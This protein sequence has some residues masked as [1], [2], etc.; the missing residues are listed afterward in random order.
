[1]VQQ[2]L[3]LPHRSVNG[4]NEV[5]D[6]REPLVIIGAN[7]SGKSRLGAWIEQNQEKPEKVHRISAQRALDFSEYAPLKSLE[8]AENELFFGI[9][10]YQL[11][12]YG[13]AV[14]AKNN[15][16]WQL[17][18]RPPLSV[19]PLLNDYDRVLSVLFARKAQR[20]SQ[21][22]K[23]VRELQLKRKNE[24]PEMPDSPDEVLI[25]LWNDLLPHRKLLIEDGK[26]TVS[27]PGV[28]NTYQG[29]EMSDGERVTLYLMAQCLCTPPD[30]VVIIDEPEIHLH[31]SLMSKLWSKI[32]EAQPSCLFIYITHDL[33]FAASRVG[34]RKIW[35][36][37][38]DGNRW[39]WDEVP[40]TEGLPEPV[41]LEIVGSRKKILFVEGEKGS[42]D[43][44]LYQAIYPDFLIM[45]RG[46]CEKVIESTKAMRDNLSLHHVDAFGLIDMDYRSQEE[47]DF[48]KAS[49]IFTLDVAEVENLLCVREVLDIVA[50]CLAKD[51]Q[52]T[53]AQVV[54][55]V[56]QKLVEEQEIQVSRRSANQIE[57]SL[58][59]LNTKARG[60]AELTTS[61]KSLV[62]SIDIENIYNSNFNIYQ[63]I[64][65]NNDY[66][67]ALLFY[68][69]KGL[70][71][72]ISLPLGL[73]PGEYRDFVLRLLSSENKDAIVAG[74]KKYA[75]TIL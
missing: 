11:P 53:Y 16:R 27:I 24:L 67:K 64:I 6:C 28:G 47:A 29:R 60:K 51:P 38:Y 44:K 31:K 41:L 66:K 62:S 14:F 18:N 33:E 20:D 32:E 8:Q 12:R 54:D 19:T 37:S 36:K 73:R 35:I 17:G 1:M 21:L 68:N 59:M 58:N 42:L 46:N 25:R 75:P 61:F 48:L 74:L 72:M 55:F 63:E 5:L 40:E 13:S 23:R 22:A 71:K 39:I 9:A 10:D 3:I 49:G 26:I 30:S 65:A 56:I 70:S 69:N 43:Y 4:L 57:F 7:G 15:Y 50:K 52:D 45:P 2:K 34:S